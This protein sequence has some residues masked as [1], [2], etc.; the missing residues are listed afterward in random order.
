MN[1][2][3]LCLNVGSGKTKIEGFTSVDIMPGADIQADFRTL[4][5]RES[6]IS[7]IYHSHG[8]EHFTFKEVNEILGLFRKWLKPEG[9]LF[10]AVPDEEKIF[11]FLSDGY[12]CD[13]LV[14]LVYGNNRYETDIHKSGW[15]KN[16]LKEKLSE[17][18]FEI[19]EEFEPFVVGEDGTGFDAS[20][21]WFKDR[22]GVINSIS[23]NFKCVLKK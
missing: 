1:N 16:S 2:G 14:G 8:I 5:I 6:S 17:F 23:I 22:Y 3:K 10:I 7:K 19:L 9:I 12:W 13:Y 18:G 11:K 15:C 4:S 20:S 21:M